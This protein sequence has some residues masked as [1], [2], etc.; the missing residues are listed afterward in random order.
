MF[1]QRVCLL[2]SN[3]EFQ[4]QHDPTAGA[5]NLEEAGA[6]PGGDDPDGQCGSAGD[7]RSGGGEDRWEGHDGERHIRHIIE[8]GLY[9]HI[10]DRLAD[11]GQRQHA[12]EIAGDGEHRDVE[13][14]VVFH[15]IQPPLQ[16]R[17]ASQGRGAQRQR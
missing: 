7:G 2:F 6:L 9:K 14:G 13:I 8:E 3:K 17:P 16:E 1:Q 12:D 4:Y 5:G 11:Q 10:C 15:I